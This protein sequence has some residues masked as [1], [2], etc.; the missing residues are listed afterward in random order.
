MGRLALGIALLCSVLVTHQVVAQPDLGYYDMV[1]ASSS[2]AMRESLHE[3][4]DDHIRFPYTSST[5]DTWDILEI[6]DENQ[7]VPGDII[8]VYR[9][10]SYAKKNGGNDF[11]NR[12]HTWPK[13]YGFPDNGPSLNYPYT[14]MHHLFLADSDYNFFRSN[15]P[16]DNCDSSCS[17]YATEFNNDRGGIGGGYPGDSNWTDGLYTEGRWEAWA[18]RKGD[19]ARAL[20]YMDVRYAGGTHGV[21]G[22]MEPDLILTD[23]RTLMDQSNTGNNEAVGYTGLLTVLL[24]WHRQ[25]PVDLIE[26]QH[27]ETVASFQGNRNPFIDHPEWAACVFEDECDTVSAVCNSDFVS[28]EELAIVV[29]P[30]G[31]DDTEN[32]QCA[33][34]EAVKDGYPVVGMTTGTYFISDINIENFTGTLEGVTRASTIINVL[35]DSIDCVSMENA[36]RTSSVIKFI[37]GEPR[38]RFVTIRANKPC[39]EEN[40]VQSILHFTGA[41]A[42]VENCDN[43]VIFGVVDRVRIEGGTGSPAGS[44]RAILVSAEGNQLGGCK[45]NLL[46]TFKLNRSDVV[47]FP[48]GLQTVMKA[49]AQVDVNFNNFDDNLTAVSLPDTNQNTTITNNKI[50]AI[51]VNTTPGYGVVI[52][53][54]TA[55]APNTTRV[56]I[57]KN[58]FNMSSSSGALCYAIFGGQ[59]GRI[60]NLSVVITNNTFKLGGSMT[61]GIS[62][63]DISNTHVSANRFSGDGEM[64]VHVS[65]TSP[66][67]G[68]TV[69]ANQGLGSFNS[70]AKDVFLDQNTSECIIGAAQGADVGDTGSGNTVLP[71]Y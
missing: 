57:N 37:R 13:S 12:E 4:I 28:R 67:T 9:N 16:Y 18:G 58:E 17:Q 19:M 61:R 42:M 40:Q 3:I 53:T 33:L 6:A 41:S 27:H 59:A 54:L 32:L 14:D 43:D 38:I 55:E 29:R 22:Y 65:G 21:T 20:M 68:W 46:G 48:L 45:T 23:D 71:Q 39:S 63:S 51:D 56:V 50:N 31:V 34:D 35:D 36:G 25:D 70:T 26:I 24:Q 5:T 69:T 62:L 66:V 52:R 60:A 30:T 2:E 1:D 47:S 15:K 7:D 8:T 10:I 64:A 11:Y 44:S 49:G